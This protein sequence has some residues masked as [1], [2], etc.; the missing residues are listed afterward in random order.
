MEADLNTSDSSSD[1]ELEAIRCRLANGHRVVFMCQKFWIQPTAEDRREGQAATELQAL[2]IYSNGELGS[3]RTRL[4]YE[5]RLGKD[6]ELDGLQPFWAWL[7]E[8]I[9]SRA[10]YDYDTLDDLMADFALELEKA[11]VE[12]DNAVSHY[13]HLPELTIPSLFDHWDDSF[14]NDQEDANSDFQLQ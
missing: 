5:F 11:A 13:E 4:A 6:F 10:L 14:S 7:R 12:Q 1:E 8:L 3:Q 9:E 2:R